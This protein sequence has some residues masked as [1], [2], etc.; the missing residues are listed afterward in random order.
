VPAG[1]YKPQSSGG[2]FDQA[3]FYYLWF[4]GVSECYAVPVV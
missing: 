4:Q 2:R 3:G 1:H